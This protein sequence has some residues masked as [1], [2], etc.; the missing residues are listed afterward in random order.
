MLLVLIVEIIL[1][2]YAGPPAS[3]G[4]Y[5]CCGRARPRGHACGRRGG[6]GLLA[7]LRQAYS[8][9]AK[10]KTIGMLWDVAHVLAESSAPARPA[11]LRRTGRPRGSR[12]NPPADRT[13][14]HRPTTSPT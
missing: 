11:L 7:L 6:P 1:V 14:H 12:P 8:D 13:F 4:P 10:R 9:Q 3:L 5:P 2:T